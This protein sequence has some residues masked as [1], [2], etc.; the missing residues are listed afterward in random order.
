MYLQAAMQKNCFLIRKL[1]GK[2]SFTRKKP[3]KIASLLNEIRRQKYDLLIDPKDHQSS[4]SSVFARIIRA[5]RKIGFNP[6][7]KS[8]FNDSLPGDEANKKLHYSE[9]VL[10]PLELFGQK[11]P[12][13]PVKPILDEAPESSE[14]VIAFFEE[15]ASEPKILVNISASRMARMWPEKNWIDFF[16]TASFNGRFVMSFA[17]SEKEMA[18]RISN[19]S[20]NVELFRTSGFMDVVSL[21]KNCDMVVTPDTSI[22]HIASAFDKPLISM[23]CNIPKMYTKFHPLSTLQIILKSP[24]GVDSIESITPSDLRNAFESMLKKI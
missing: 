10:R 1:S 23:F 24:E 6:P 17:P 16:N 22:V 2:Y 9:K 21:V 13:K 11:M 20:P 14:K 15:C 5:D 3:L 4:E 18:E 8:Y 19:A 7:G 12:G